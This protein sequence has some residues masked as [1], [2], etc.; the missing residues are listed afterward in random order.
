MKIKRLRKFTVLITKF[1][2]LV[3]SR[4]CAL[5]SG[6]PRARRS[7]GSSPNV[8]QVRDFET[9]QM[10][11]RS[12]NIS[13]VGR[14]TWIVDREIVSFKAKARGNN[15]LSSSHAKN[16]HGLHTKYN[17]GRARVNHLSIRKHYNI[18]STLH[19]ASG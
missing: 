3:R 16:S 2:A 14:Q 7:A 9:N 15:Q 10:T 1:V 4:S 18:G 13:A 11:T 5:S 12:V 19:A 8:H 6:S 17:R